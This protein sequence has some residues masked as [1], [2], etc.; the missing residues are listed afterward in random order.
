MILHERKILKS[1]SFITF[2]YYK[3]L[4]HDFI[5]KLKLVWFSFFTSEDN[6]LM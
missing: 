4:R 5:K 3:I 6:L 2:N 1:D